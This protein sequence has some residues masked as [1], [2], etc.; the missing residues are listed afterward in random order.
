MH[1]LGRVLEHSISHARVRYAVYWQGLEPPPTHREDEGIIGLENLLVP[2]MSL[3]PNLNK[4]NRSSVAD[5][6]PTMIGIRGFEFRD[7]LGSH[8]LDDNLRVHASSK[9]FNVDTLDYHP[10]VQILPC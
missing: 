5:N 4:P 3:D 7:K 1:V 10:V 8:T 2:S 6:P 9:T